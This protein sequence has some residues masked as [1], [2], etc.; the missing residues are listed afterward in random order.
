[1]GLY[2]F[3][4]LARSFVSGDFVNVDEDAAAEK[5]VKR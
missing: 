3:S 5:K 1:M 2:F 4:S